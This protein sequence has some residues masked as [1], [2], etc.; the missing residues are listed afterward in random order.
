[1]EWS[2]GIAIHGKGNTL[3]SWVGLSFMAWRAS[4]R[5]DMNGMGSLCLTF[6]NLLGARPYGYR[7]AY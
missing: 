1:M 6:E 4:D 2:S 7:V 5:M 3:G